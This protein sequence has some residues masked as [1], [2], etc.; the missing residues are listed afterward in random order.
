[1]VRLQVIVFCSFC[2]TVFSSHFYTKYMLFW[3]FKKRCFHIWVTL[4]IDLRQEFEC[5]WLIW[6]V[7]PRDPDREVGKG[8]KSIKGTFS[9]SYYSGQLGFDPLGSPGR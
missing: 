2:L 1:M 8:D 3:E 7:I 9:G 6:E 4:E 5:K